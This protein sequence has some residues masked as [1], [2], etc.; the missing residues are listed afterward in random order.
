MYNVN[1]SA[2][3]AISAIRGRRYYLNTIR[4]GFIISV[5]WFTQNT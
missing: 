1:P 4:P 2:I 3:S 5:E